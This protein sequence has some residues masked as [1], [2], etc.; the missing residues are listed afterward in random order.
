MPTNLEQ[1]IATIARLRAPDGCPWDL[2]QTH[3]SLARYAIEEAYEVQEAIHSGE[4]EKLKEE[5]GDLL[6]QVVLHAQ[7]AK[8]AGTFDIE[9]VARGINEKMIRRHPHVFGDK[10]IGDAKAVVGQWEEIKKKEKSEAKSQSGAN[11]DAPPSAIDGVPIAMP[12]LL[13]ALKISEKAVTQ[14]FEWENEGQVWEKLDS[15][16]IELKEAI[17]NPDMSRQD[18]RVAAKHE[19]DLEM[20]DVLF[21]LVNIGRWHGLNPEESLLLAIDKFKQRF[22]E[23]EILSDAPLKTLST[24]QLDNLWTRAK[25]NLKQQMPRSPG[26]KYGI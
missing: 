15:E 5:L 25:I 1:F 17:S 24:A 23:M 9:D 6:L 12:A 11:G 4:P 10:K 21:T 7:V 20:G 26:T 14:G 2:E 8:D 18:K 3:E 13:Q 16:L 22:R 19:I